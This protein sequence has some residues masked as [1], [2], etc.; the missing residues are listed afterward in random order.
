MAELSLSSTIPLNNGVGIPALGLGVFKVPNAEAFKV[1]SEALEIG[2]RHIDTAAYYQNERGVGRAVRESG[3]AREE[4]FVTTKLWHTDNGYREALAAID[5]SLEALGMDYVDLYL[6]HWPRGNRQEAWRAMER[7]LD[8]GK[9]RAVGVSNYLVRH[10]DETIARSPVVPAIDQIEFSP[11]L[12]QK[13]LL[14]YC[15]E[16]GIILEAYSPLTRGRRLDD[17]RLVALARE[18]GRTPAQMMIRWVLQKGMVVIPKSVHVERMRENVSVFDFE[19]S[20]EDEAT[21][22]SFNEDY[23]TTWNPEGIP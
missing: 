15:R 18:Y 5:G 14:S 20:A 11:F 9:A 22:D 6:V 1:V 16:K 19:I 3:L 23:H 4:V 2:Y 8:E 17:P 13:D 21:M 12:Y 10:L 7:I